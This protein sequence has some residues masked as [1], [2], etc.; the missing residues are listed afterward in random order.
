MC[1]TSFK[2]TLFLFLYLFF[3]N[4]FLCPAATYLSSFSPSS[5]PY[6]FS[7][8]IS[9]MFPFIYRHIN[10]AFVCISRSLC[11]LSLCLLSFSVSQPVCLSVRP[12]VC[13]FACICIYLSCL[14]AHCLS[15]NLSVCASVQ[16]FVSQSVYLSFCL[17]TCL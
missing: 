12:F 17:F 2:P 6:L 3:L 16:M 9:S 14:A 11:F 10:S 7:I 5:F 8:C 13:L 1:L 15:I 4:P